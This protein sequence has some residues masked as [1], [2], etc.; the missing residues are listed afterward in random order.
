MA[1]TTTIYLSEDTKVRV[2]SAA[3]RADKTTREFIL[4]A[5]AEKVER[6]EQRAGLEAEADARLAQIVE[7]EKTIPWADARNYLVERLA[8]R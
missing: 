5:I 4:A 6:G 7:T 2:A 1:T 3:E 8:G